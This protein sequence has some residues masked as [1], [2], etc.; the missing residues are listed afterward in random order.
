MGGRQQVKIQR[1]VLGTAALLVVGGVAL[2]AGVALGSGS[3]R[4]DGDPPKAAPGEQTAPSTA[5]AKATMPKSQA[6]VHFRTDGTIIGRSKK[7]VAV[8]R[9]SA[10]T[11]CVELQQSIHVS[12]ETYAHGS[13]DYLL[14][15]TYMV[16]VQQNSDVTCLGHGYDNSVPI[17]TIGLVAGTHQFVDAAVYLTFP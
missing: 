13:V 15:P 4:Q 2:M 16:T 17:L 12:S 9:L 11:Y 1:F 8:H 5:R 7:V 14:T 3:A 6:Y 10:G